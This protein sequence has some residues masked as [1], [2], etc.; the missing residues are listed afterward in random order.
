MTKD[1]T[2]KQK[3][4]L[5]LLGY[6]LLAIG[7][8]QFAYIESTFLNTYFNLKIVGVIFFITYLITFWAI[9][10]Y[11]NYIAKFNNLKTS[12]FA[13]LMEIFGL[14]LFIIW[15]SSFTAI[16]TFIIYIITTNLI[17]INFDIFL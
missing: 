9:N 12:I 16:L 1:L 13:L 5:L 6:F 14:V 3:I 8:A 7:F 4:Y 2:I 17:G 10:T 11:P 15:P